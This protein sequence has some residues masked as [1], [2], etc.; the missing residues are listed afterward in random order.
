V[1]REALPTDPTSSSSVSISVH[2][3]LTLLPK[4]G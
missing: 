2:Q 3:W 4:L 1:S